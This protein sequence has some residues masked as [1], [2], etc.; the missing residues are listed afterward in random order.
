MSN[1]PHDARFADTFFVVE[2]TSFEVLCLWREWAKES[3]T[4][5]GREP[6]RV[7][8]VQDQLGFTYAVGVDTI[9]HGETLSVHATHIAGEWFIIEGR[10]VLFWHPTSKV[11]SHY[12]IDDWFERYCTP[13]KWDGAAKR[14]A[15]TDAMNFHLCLDAIR[16]ANAKR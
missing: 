15:F 4:A 7:E 3:I 11:V 1:R 16:Q 5:L 10:R 13:P 14:R 9:R 6:H 8:W 12:H 2:A